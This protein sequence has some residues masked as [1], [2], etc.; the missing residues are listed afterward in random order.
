[1]ARK[2][3]RSKTSITLTGLAGAVLIIIVAILR[4]LTGGSFDLGTA[5]TA[6]PDSNNSNANNKVDNGVVPGGEL[7]WLKVYFTNPNP[8]D[9]TGNGI[10]RF[11]VPVLDAAKQTIDVASFDF[12]LPSVTNALVNAA[13]RGV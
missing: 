13:K 9:N 2:S 10:D 11:V 3:R 6:V 1:M 5:P 8:P 7:S 4:I 12:T